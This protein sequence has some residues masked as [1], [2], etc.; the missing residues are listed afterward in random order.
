MVRLAISV[1]GSTE[2][3][4]MKLVIV[5]YLEKHKIFATPLLISKNGGDVSLSRI[6]KDLNNLARSFDKVTTFYDFYGFHGK[7]EYFPT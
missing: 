3:R 5:P 7:E 2:E 6:K 4:F 1:E